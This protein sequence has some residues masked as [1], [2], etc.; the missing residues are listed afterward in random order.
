MEFLI[1]FIIVVLS[2]GYFTIGDSASDKACIKK[3]GEPIIFSI[4][5]DKN[6]TKGILK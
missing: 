6:L 4:C 1:S 3:G 2:I 5:T